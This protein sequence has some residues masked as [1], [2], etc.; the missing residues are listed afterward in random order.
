MIT[1]IEIINIYFILIWNCIE[2]IKNW[3]TNLSEE[4]NLP[5]WLINEFTFYILLFTALLGLINFIKRLIKI[6]YIGR[7]E[8][9]LNKDLEYSSFSRN[10]VELATRYYIPTKYQNVSPSEDEE[11]GSKYIASAKNELIPLFL[12]KI[13]HYGGGDNKY[14][15]IL[16][17]A[18]MGKTTFMINLYLSYKSK[19]K[20]LWNPPKKNILLYSL[21]DIRTLQRVKEIENKVDTILLLDAFD[22]DIEAIN[23]YKNRINQILDVVNEFRTIVITSRTQFFPSEVEEPY[24]TGYI[25][26]GDSNTRRNFQKLYL[27]VF[28]NEDIK[29]YLHKRIPF[30]NIGKYQKALEIT[31]MSPNLVV[32]PMLLSHIEDLVNSKEVFNYTYQIYQTLIDRWVERE[33]LKPGIELKYGKKKY[34][35][36]L[37][38]FSQEL[39]V[40]MYLNK[41]KRGGYYV[42][43]EEGF[44]ENIELNIVEFDNLN[45]SETERRSRSLLNRNA[46]GQYKFS[47]KSILEF[48]LAKRIIENKKF[49]DDFNFQGNDTAQLFFNE[50][51]LN[52]IL[53]PVHEKFNNISNEKCKN[54]N[55]FQSIGYKEKV[56]IIRQSDIY[57]RKLL[58]IIKRIYGGN[59][60]FRVGMRQF[61]YLFKILLYNNIIKELSGVIDQDSIQNSLLLFKVEDWQL[62]ELEESIKS[63]E[64][65]FLKEIPTMKLSNVLDYDN[66]EHLEQ[67]EIKEQINQSE[68]SSYII[69]FNTYSLFL[70][71]V[72]KSSLYLFFLNQ[73]YLLGLYNNTTNMKAK[74]QIEQ[75]IGL[76]FSIF[77]KRFLDSSSYLF[78]LNYLIIMIVLTNKISMLSY[79]NKRRIIK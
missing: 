65:Y 3:Y 41:E 75:L 72:S 2:N 66:F 23:N 26:F 50:M 44:G 42:T 14:Y 77:K 60:E 11:P 8:K 53:S 49:A 30:Y 74:W 33:S 37:K 55:N 73:K 10:D 16:A 34:A 54:F 7:Y 76:T 12:K 20:K 40:D 17:D 22:E 25:S 62:N 5:N 36:L 29:K 47:H 59:A 21:G 68:I 70:K 9:K 1:S 64:R 67:T 18:G 69:L 51:V 28:T 39:A 71:N 61:D 63:L 13:F 27:S 19:K 35:S 45:L 46:N 52:E 15:L 58:K 31:R 6:F 48:F 78:P 38:V 57:N 56:E 79:T 32:R 43:T 24:T 4:G